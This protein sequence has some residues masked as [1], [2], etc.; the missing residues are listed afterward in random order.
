MKV[1]Y[2]KDHQRLPIKSWCA[3]IEE[4]AMEQ[5]LNL[6]N[7]PALFRHVAL[8]PDCHRGYGMPIGGVIA[9]KGAVIP[10]AVGVDIGCG[11]IAVQSDFPAK[12]L[13][14]EGIKEIMGKTR[15]LIPIGFNHHEHSQAWSGFDHIPDIPI[16][17]QML[18]S[19][20]KQLGTLGGGN[21]FIE[22]QKGDDGML[23][24]MIHS[25]SRNFGYKIA[26]MYNDIAVKLC[27]RWKSDI[28]DPELAFLPIET[29]EA[30]EYLE[31]MDY[32]LLFA[33]QNR[34]LM[35]TKLKYVVDGSLVCNFTQEINIH[36]N[37]AA[38]E[39]HFGQNVVV[40]RKGAT[41]ARIGQ[42]GII[43]GSMG[44]P[45]YIVEGL[46]NPE[47]F[48]SCS[49]GAGRVMGRM[50]A[51]RTLTE[52]ECDAAMAGVVFGR[53]GKTRKGGL[54]FGEAPQAYKNIDAVIEAELDLIKPVVKLQPLGV[55]KG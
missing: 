1:I 31:A 16:I 38:W 13:T 34:Y 39:N 20:R 42:K 49:H 29:P 48:N 51:S 23:W 3:D 55:I 9:C 11:M 54:D 37:Y 7:H 45:S 30:K 50:Q 4:G 47:S 25:G 24:L 53:W 21:H 26:K 15:E 6:S 35:M 44:T 2:D 14:E 8:M 46:G 41:L 32:A 18:N 10:N 22:L 40:H 43:P 36:H 27:E 12:H 19:A 5:A 52:V 33:Q 17:R 28:P